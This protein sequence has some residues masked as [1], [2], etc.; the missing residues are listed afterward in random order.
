VYRTAAE[1]TEAAKK[2]AISRREAFE[3]KAKLPF[4]LQENRLLRE[5]LIQTGNADKIPAA[6]D[7][8]QEPCS[9]C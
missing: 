1:L 4:L 2:S 7:I 6:I 8:I 3:A 5:L 9:R